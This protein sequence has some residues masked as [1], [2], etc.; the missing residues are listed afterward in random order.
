[1]G[2]KIVILTRGALRHS[3][4][5]KSFGLADEIEVLRTYCETG[6][7]HISGSDLLEEAR[8]NNETVRIKHLERRARSE[9]DYFGPFVNLTPDYSNPVNIPGGSINN[10][11]YYQE[12][13]ELDPDLL[14][15]YGCSLV[16]D[17]LL[18][19][20][21]G[22]FLNVHLGL[23]PYYRG[24]GTNFWPLVNGE[25]EYVGATFMHIDQG[26]DTGEIIHQ[27][28]ARVHPGDGPHGI[29]NRLISDVG[30]VYPE[31]VRSFDDLHS[32]EQPPEPEEDHYYRSNDYNP[33]ATVRLYENFEN[34]MVEEYLDEQDKRISDVPIVKH[35]VIDENEL[36]ID[37]K[38]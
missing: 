14:V 28:R 13:V 37:P 2:A 24:T 21:E 19:E 17:P 26:V 5:R 33:E 1:M 9:H 11:K 34:N 6:V 22:R 3:F 35:P 8:K 30:Q 12:I 27:L 31:L 29:G 7:E 23:S 16:R 15:A 20:Y 38:M 4:I 36:L 10:D 32:V 25:P 18:G